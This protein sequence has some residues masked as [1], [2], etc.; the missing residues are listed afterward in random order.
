MSIHD[1]SHQFTV[2]MDFPLQI[3]GNVS[4]VCVDGD[5]LIRENPPVKRAIYTV[6]NFPSF[7]FESISTAVAAEAGSLGG[8]LMC[9]ALRKDFVERP[10]LKRNGD[11]RGSKLPGKSVLQGPTY[12]LMHRKR[13]MESMNSLN[14]SIP[15][16]EVI[17]DLEA[18]TQRDP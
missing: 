1:F 11:K 15:H 14:R 18:I 10:W 7:T 16:G 5:C 13:E 4:S 8:V 17:T 3:A 12:I 6:P 9:D 2:S